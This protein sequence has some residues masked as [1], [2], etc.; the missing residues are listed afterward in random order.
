MGG[1]AAEPGFA[2][3]EGY[4]GEDPGVD[5]VG[6]AGEQFQLGFVA[7]FTVKFLALHGVVGRPDVV[8]QAVDE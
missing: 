5:A 8:F 1:L 6:E 3:E 7:V 2:E 4:V